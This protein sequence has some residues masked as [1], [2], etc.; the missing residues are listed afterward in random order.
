ML[1]I[2]VATAVLC[3][4]RSQSGVR[5]GV[6]AIVFTQFPKLGLQNRFCSVTY[7][8]V[9]LNQETSW[10]GTFFFL[11]ELHQQDINNYNSGRCLYSAVVVL[12]GGYCVT[13]ACVALGCVRPLSRT[14]CVWK[15]PGHRVHCVGERSIKK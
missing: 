11:C 15:Y 13:S 7:L 1:S 6:E 5:H 2:L 10:N 9:L 4:G 3:F 8:C 12:R 14:T